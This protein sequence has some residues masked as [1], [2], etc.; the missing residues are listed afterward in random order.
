MSHGFDNSRFDHE[1][2]SLRVFFPH[3]PR[4]FELRDGLTIGSDVD[5]DMFIHHIDVE[6]HHAQIS[7]AG[8]RWYVNG[9]FT[10]HVFLLDG[11]AFRDLGLMRGTTF[12]VGPTVI[13]CVASSEV[14]RDE[15][16]PEA[17]PAAGASSASSASSVSSASAASSLSSASSGGM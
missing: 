4:T 14:E 12:R 2:L 15:P 6:P 16:I 1:P 11:S 13:Q 10:N 8:G 7:R 17:R 5:C 9:V 3:G